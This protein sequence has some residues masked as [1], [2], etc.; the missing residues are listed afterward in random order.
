MI[1]TPNTSVFDR[2]IK[3]FTTFDITDELEEVATEAVTDIKERVNKGVAS[4]GSVMDT[5][6]SDKVGKYSRRYADTRAKNGK[7]TSIRD[8]NLTGEMIDDFVLIDKRVNYV[9]GGFST[10]TQADKAEYNE[11]Y[12]NKKAFDL[13]DAEQSN[14]VKKVNDKITEKFN[15]V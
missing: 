11:I 5:N 12:M 13:S 7:G 1:A 14:V 6:S 2:Y 8:L 3:F 10:K 9:A 15:K 4:D